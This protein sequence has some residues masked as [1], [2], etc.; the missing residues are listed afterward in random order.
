MKYVL[1]LVLALGFS[2]CS[3]NR[4]LPEA[5]EGDLSLGITIIGV[6]CCEG[7]LRLGVY[8]DGRLWMKKD[9]MVR[10]RIAFVQSVEERID[11]H[12]LPPGDY[13]VAVHQDTN[14]NGR[15]D[16]RFFVLP[17]EPYGFSNNVGKYGPASF[18][19]ATITLDRSKDIVIELN[20]L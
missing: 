7:V 1:V 3:T 2:A 5:V 15:M 20:K 9:G 8:K 18:R 14:G 19:A 13:A 4:V 11:I 12:G 6:E 16:K 10:G 17:R